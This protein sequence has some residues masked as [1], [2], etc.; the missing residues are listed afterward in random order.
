[1]CKHDIVIM[2]S[3]LADF[4]LPFTQHVSFAQPR[5]QRMRGQIGH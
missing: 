2:E 3:G 5:T 1:M 4:E